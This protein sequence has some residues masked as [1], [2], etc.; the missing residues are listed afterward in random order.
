MSQ[1]F[2]TKYPYMNSKS[3]TTKE[4]ENI[5]KALKSKN[6]QGHDDISTKILNISS[7]FISSPLN[8]IC[9]TTPSIGMLPDRLKYSVIKPLYKKGNTLDVSNDRSVSLQTSFSNIFEKIMQST[10]NGPFN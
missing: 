7:P 4:I 5:I 2:T 10:L 6:S 9:S 8:Y 1:D 3:S